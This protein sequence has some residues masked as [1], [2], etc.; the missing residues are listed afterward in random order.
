MR[1]NDFFELLSI[2]H[3]LKLTVRNWKLV[4]EKLLSFCDGLVSGA[5]GSFLRGV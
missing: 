5:Q 4:V 1:E 3:S 2:I